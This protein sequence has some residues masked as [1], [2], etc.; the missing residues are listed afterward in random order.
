MYMCTNFYFYQ[1]IKL[2]RILWKKTIIFLYIYIYIFI[3]KLNHEWNIYY[4][5]L[6]YDET[7]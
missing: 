1:A 3:N 2:K 7:C 6:G 5:K 4:S